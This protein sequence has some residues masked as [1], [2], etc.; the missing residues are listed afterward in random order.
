MQIIVL[1]SRFMRAKS[2]NIGGKQFALIVSS[3]LMVII[4]IAAIFTYLT[5]KHA[6]QTGSSQL[7]NELVLS[8]VKEEQAKNDKYV[9][10]NLS[11][12]AVKLGELQAQLMRID[13]LG[14]RVQGLS[15]ISPEEFNFK[16][17]PGQGGIDHSASG[18]TQ[19][20]SM[21]ELKDMLSQI[22]LASVQR[23]DYMN[24]VETAL[25]GGKVK[26]RLL[27]TNM[28]VHV[29]YNSSSFGWRIDPFS[30]KKAFHE[31]LDFPAPVGTA[32]VAAA[33]GVVTESLLHAQYGNMVDI[34]HGNDFMTRYAHLSKMLVKVGDIVKRGQKIGLVGTTGRS[35]GPHLHFEVRMRTVAQDPRKFLALGKSDG[36]LKPTPRFVAKNH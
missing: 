12:M 20:L 26:T 5:L 17:K 32:V 34:D 6:A 16:E 36:L 10:E 3:L 28:P 35:T 8:L 24:A 11:V 23:Y 4:A 21:Q 29:A 13:S 27:P 31:G 7:V 9:K 15:G 30:G 18:E 1:H 33:D 22:S 25:I 2:L 19:D 14:E